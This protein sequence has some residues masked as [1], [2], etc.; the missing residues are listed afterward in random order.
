MN[1]NHK[2][3][4]CSAVTRVSAHDLVFLSPVDDPMYGIPIGDGSTGCLIW[5]ETD[6]LVF[7]VNNTDLWDF[8]DTRESF[9]N[10]GDEM[11]S[12][13]SLRHA[14]RLELRFD[15]PVFDLLYQKDYEARLSLADARM[16][17]RAQTPFSDVS[18]AA[19]ASNE[20]FVTVIT[21]EAEFQD[22]AAPD[23][24]L[25]R[26]GSRTFQGWYSSVK[27][28][29]TINL[30]GTD[31]TADTEN[32]AV[33]IT[34]KLTG[35]SFCIAAAIESAV[36]AFAVERVHGRAGK[37]AL[38]NSNKINFKIYLT[39]ADS[40]SEAN[41]LALAKERLKAAKQTGTEK[42]YERHTGAWRE[43]WERAYVCLPND[44]D[45]IENLW[46]LN[47]YYANSEMRGKYPPHFCNG[48]WGFQRDFVPWNYYFHY[49]MQ[50][51]YW[52]LLAANQPEL[53]KPYMDFRFNQL[54]YA[55]RFAL[56]HKG[57]E[58]AL[59]TDV[60]SA[61]GACDL[62]TVDNLTPGSQ[63]AQTFWKYYKFT[64][65]RE[66]LLNTAWRIIRPTALFYANLVKLGE[67]GLY[68]IYRAEAYEASPMMDDTITDHSAMRAIFRIA[69]DCMDELEKFGEL[70][71]EENYREKIRNIYEN[72]SPI[73]TVEL[74][75]DE[76]YEKDGK[77]YIANGVGKD[78]PVNICLAP[79]TGVFCGEKRNNSLEDGEYWNNLPAGTPIRTTFN[80][81]HL[82]HYYGFPHPELSAVMPS[83][84]VGLKDKGSELFDAFVNILRLEKRQKVNE[85]Q[86]K[87]NDNDDVT[88]M[89]WMIHPIVLAR[90]GLAEELIN[91]VGD[92]IKTWQWYPNGFGHYGGYIES[93]SESNLRFYRRMVGGF[94]FPAWQFR[95]FD[96]E[97]L[98]VIA[99]TVNEMLLQ[100]HENRIRL[101]PAFLTDFNA[102][103]KLAAE[104][105]FIVKS[106][107]KKGEV[108]FAEIESFCGGIVRLVDPWGE[109]RVYAAKITPAGIEDGSYIKTISDM[110]DNI[111]EIQ[112]DAG[113]RILIT[114][115][116]DDIKKWQ[117]DAECCDIKEK[118]TSEKHFGR[119]QLGS[120]RMF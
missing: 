69:A 59:Y 109:N 22:S 35:H 88:T 77:K 87:L 96:F 32:G 8:Q 67:D 85:E 65:N 34:Q 104:N 110:A 56:K 42:I 73:K 60:S 9:S 80:S 44:Y 15:A 30:S 102:S 7:A 53:L 75:K 57:V 5:T 18:V 118:N 19:F 70:K 108:L 92:V 113:E 99:T 63:I 33:Y 12:R 24:L 112:V 107:M 11:E 101:F 4:S 97:T 25:E 114:K 119:S 36:P 89:G 14:G 105:G 81:K 79:V 10:W 40:D 26:W 93:I 3:S 39:V 27:R 46:Y 50:L 100:S 43:V 117:T 55:E 103:F 111:A 2:K 17:L 47:I 83:G 74:Q 54:P 98:P 64:G 61:T 106:Q 13:T 120:P 91:I 90:L 29:P 62:E 37:F 6:K 45:Y 28:D 68:H 16:N 86:L 38:M 58:G 115:T 94:P 48:I 95:H 31:A 20:T 116:F 23:I 1:I 82:K 76:Y 41:A 78:K 51:A 66:F 84:I 72:L 49:N 71:A 52:P 21:C